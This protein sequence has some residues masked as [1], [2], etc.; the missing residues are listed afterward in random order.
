MNKSYTR[1]QVLETIEKSF[2]GSKAD[3]QPEFLDNFTFT[4]EE[5]QEL[6]ARFPAMESQFRQ[7]ENY[8]GLCQ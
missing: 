5:V 2:P 4:E 3:F 8:R 7:Q 1:K 6:L